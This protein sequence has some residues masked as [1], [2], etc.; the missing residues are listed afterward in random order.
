ME[1]CRFPILS[2]LLQ[3]KSY[4]R[5]TIETFQS[6]IIECVKLFQTRAP[7]SSR[8]TVWIVAHQ[9]AAA[10]H[11]CWAPIFK[12]ISHIISRQG[13]TF[14]S[15]V[16]FYLATIV[17]IL[18]G[19]TSQTRQQTALQHDVERETITLS[20]LYIG[21]NKVE[22]GPPMKCFLYIWFVL[23]AREDLWGCNGHVGN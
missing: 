12:K 1:G 23:L 9:T 15:S 14:Y 2:S 16:S 7:S 4:K 19:Y 3:H 11:C 21:M 5:F 18:A 6:I 8:Y 13:K 10:K 17:S 20:F 22:H